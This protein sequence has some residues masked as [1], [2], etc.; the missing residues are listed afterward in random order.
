[1][2]K[3]LVFLLIV[4]GFFLYKL[5]VLNRESVLVTVGEQ[6]VLALVAD[7]GD[8]RSRG[9]SGHKSLDEGEGMLFIF[10]TPGI[11]GFWMKDMEFAIDIVWIGEDLRVLGVERGVKPESYPEVF[12]PEEEIKYALEVA[13]TFS[14]TALFEVG[15]LVS[16]GQ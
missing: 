9:L 4:L 11:Y 10:D 13:H 1:M 2:K 8:E 3:L 6:K 14:D 5:P 7:S 12:Y 16:I 15:D